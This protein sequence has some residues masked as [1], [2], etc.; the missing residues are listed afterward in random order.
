MLALIREH[1]RK[2]HQYERR[3]GQVRPIIST[4]YA[5]HR[6]VA[7]GNKLHWAKASAL[8]NFPD[9][10]NQYLH[11]VLGKGWGEKQVALPVDDQHPIVQWR[12]ISSKQQRGQNP[13][14]EGF[15]TADSGA[16]FSWFRLAYDLYLIEHN[17]EFQKKLLRR[18][19]DGN[20]FQGARFEIVSAAAM[21]PAGYE[22]DFENDKL[23]GKHTEF[24]ATQKRAGNKLAVEAKSR[25]RPGVLGQKGER[26][27]PE[28]ADIGGLLRAAVAKDPEQ[29]L[30]VF[31]ELNMPIIVP[32]GAPPTALANEL[33]AA[34]TEVQAQ[35]W[36]TG[37]PAI[38]VIFYNDASPWFLE[39][40]APG[41][42]AVFAIAMWPN[43]HRHE[44]DA[45]PL[46]HT[47]MTAMYQR[48]T[49][50]NDFPE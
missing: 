21:L 28:R 24:V 37:F 33:E 20:A 13:N 44:F 39:E 36:P 16:G 31:I 9:F 15:Y 11:S 14:A 43:K 50:P 41:R 23:P 19:R 3:H 26:V 5:G 10:L 22:L 8:K 6:L 35:N 38:G 48:L 34:W 49:I 27:Q 1:E 18:L 46:L 32:D 47:V 29:P 7:V 40:L 30:L 12:T 17:V 42:R 2:E 25:H 4:E 45:R